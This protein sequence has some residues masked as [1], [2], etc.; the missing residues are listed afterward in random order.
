MLLLCV[1]AA[2]VWWGRI[3]A[4]IIAYSWVRSWGREQPLDS[5]TASTG[6]RGTYDPSQAAGPRRSTLEPTR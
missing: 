3:F 1:K 2:K 5:R 6:G 4:G